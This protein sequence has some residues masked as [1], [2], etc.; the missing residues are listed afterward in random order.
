MPSRAARIG[1]A[2]ALIATGALLAGGGFAAGGS[3]GTAYSLELSGTIDPATSKWVSHALNDAADQD[4]KVAIIRLDTPGGLDESLRDIVKDILAAPMPVIVY[5]SPNGARAASAG[6]YITE[7][8]DVA[9]MA[10]ETNIGSATP[11]SI[12][13]GGA[14]D[15]LD[16][17]ITNDARAYVRALAAGHGRNPALAERMV[18]HATNVTAAEAKRAG[19][20]DVIAPSERALLTKL[21]GFQTKGPKAQKLHTAGLQISDHDMPL[22][23]QILQLL[24]NPTIAF[25][26]LSVGLIGLAIEILSPGL[27]APG[28]LGLICFVL[29]LYGT[30][31]LPVTA[32][33]VILLVAAIALFVIEGHV[34]SHG[35]IGAS[36]VICLILSGLLLFD[37]GGGEAVSVPAI[38]AIGLILGA[39]FAFLVQRAVRARHQPVRTGYEEL[40]GTTAEVRVALDPEG[41]VFVQG[42]LWRARLANG[43]GP[44]RP[45]DRVLVQSV[46]G[47][48]LLVTPAVA[49]TTESEEGGPQ[50]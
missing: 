39:M 15:V 41:Q 7:A 31:Q 38:V 18:Q 30:A 27:I 29:G 35:V 48:T 17:K 6:V 8:A 11:I 3:G 33:G 14:S 9:A 23:Y 20:I 42:A 22:Q 25:L 40:I 32:A 1:L 34:N 13:P 16:R 47:L 10:P 12:G 44:L 21:D 50:W 37:T 24:V 43:G 46:E 36:G 19:L 5:V 28:T 4:A 45:G 49:S 26:L 2:L